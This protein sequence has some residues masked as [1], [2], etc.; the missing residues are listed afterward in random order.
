MIPPL[1]CPHCGG[2]KF[3]KYYTAM[4]QIRQTLTGENGEMEIVETFFNEV[5]FGRE[6]KTVTCANEKCH[7]RMDNPH[8]R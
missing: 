2:T 3:V 4:G 6:P 8:N 7:R 1:T 5:K